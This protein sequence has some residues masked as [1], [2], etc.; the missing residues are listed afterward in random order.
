MKRAEDVE[1][2]EKKKLTDMKSHEVKYQTGGL[3]IKGGKKTEQI[4]LFI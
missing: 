4:F 3:S 2:L 1:R